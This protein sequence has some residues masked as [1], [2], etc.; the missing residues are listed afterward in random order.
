MNNSIVEFEEYLSVK[1]ALRLGVYD[2]DKVKKQ[3]INF[4]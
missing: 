4:I 3:N 1:K 2:S